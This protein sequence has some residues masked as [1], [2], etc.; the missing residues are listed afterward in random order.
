MKHSEVSFYNPLLTFSHGILGPDPATAYTFVQLSI[1][2]SVMGFY[3][4]DELVLQRLN[5]NPVYVK[6]NGV[7]SFG[8]WVQAHLCFII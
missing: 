5:L 7:A 1:F 6:V 3:G 8:V 4:K 2:T